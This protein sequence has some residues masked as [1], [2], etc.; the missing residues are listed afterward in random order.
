MKRAQHWLSSEYGFFFP[1][2]FFFFFK[3]RLPCR[4]VAWKGVWFS[5]L[6]ARSGNQ[7]S[8]A[9]LSSC[10]KPASM[11][12]NV[13][14]T[15][16]KCPGCVFIP[17][18]AFIS[19]RALGLFFLAGCFW[20][21]AHRG[22]WLRHPLGLPK[23]LVPRPAP[24]GVLGEQ[25]CGAATQL[26]HLPSAHPHSFCGHRCHH[27]HHRPVPTRPGARAAGDGDESSMQD[28]QPLQVLELFSCCLLL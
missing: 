14:F 19:W 8:W 23:L 6:S 25:L 9:Q 26:C 5:L 21:G 2:L 13:Q 18:E 7:P 12:T 22:A 16:L 17:H 28:P 1:F 27:H 3:C 20:A 11:H 10:S 4:D 15:Y 24:H